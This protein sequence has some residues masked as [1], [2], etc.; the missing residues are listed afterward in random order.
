M[1]INR[2]GPPCPEC[3]SLTTDIRRTLRT[4]EGHFYRQ[5]ECPSCAHKF[6]TVQHTEIVAP[7]EAVATRR[8]DAS[9]H[10]PAFRDYF[11]KLLTQC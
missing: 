7:R 10:W 8:Y 3:G 2:I 4:P 5:R 1:G 11:V 9:I 6:H